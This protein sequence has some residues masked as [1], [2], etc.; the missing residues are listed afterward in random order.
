MRHGVYLL[1][2][3]ELICLG[4]EKHVKRWRQRIER[5]IVDEVWMPSPQPSKALLS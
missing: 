4:H 2:N 1:D 3:R 5:Q